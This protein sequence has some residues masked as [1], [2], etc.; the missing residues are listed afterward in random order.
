M[1]LAVIIALIEKLVDKK[2]SKT[3]DTKKLK[4]E[5]VN[6]VLEKI[7]LSQ[8]KGEKGPRGQR[9]KKGDSAY[10]IWKKYHDGTEKDF[11]N[12]LKK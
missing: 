8:I 3:V 12:W 5:I 9:G 6:E 10:D 4:S 7:E 1:K 2:L 11:L